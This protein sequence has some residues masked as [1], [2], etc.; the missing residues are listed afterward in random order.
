VAIV[1]PSEMAEHVHAELDGATLPSPQL[2]DLVSSWGRTHRSP[3]PPADRRAEVEMSIPCR[4]I[5]GESP[6]TGNAG[7]ITR[8]ERHH[9]P[10]QVA[11]QIVP[12]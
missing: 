9:T 5:I 7:E 6:Q 3:H 8:L 11:N 10:G 2:T 4:S 12:A 1:V